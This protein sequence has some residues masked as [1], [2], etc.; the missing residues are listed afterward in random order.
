LVVDDVSGCRMDSLG[1]EVSDA[2]R[3]LLL[4]DAEKKD[5]PVS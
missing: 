2:G 3:E 1:V 4:D 5:V